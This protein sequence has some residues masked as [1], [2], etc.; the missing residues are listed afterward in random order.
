[1]ASIK[2]LPLD[3]CCYIGCQPDDPLAS[4]VT[5]N[6]IVN[7]YGCCNVTHV[8][9]PSLFV[10]C[11]EWNYYYILYYWLGKNYSFAHLHY[12][13]LNESFCHK[14]HFLIRHILGAWCSIPDKAFMVGGKVF[15]RLSAL[16]DI[17]FER[18]TKWGALTYCLYSL[19]ANIERFWGGGG[20]G[21]RHFV[22][23]LLNDL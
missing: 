8:F 15:V 18:L 3:L 10:F 12:L 23:K 11:W 2:L 22:S 14:H 16:V 17:N 6:R 21:G 9:C 19:F 1:M 4:L 13:K 7:V 5:A 20:G